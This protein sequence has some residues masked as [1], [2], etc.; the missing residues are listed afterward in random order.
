MNT[1]TNEVDD[2][3]F[4]ALFNG[5]IKSCLEFVKSDLLSVACTECKLWVTLETL[6]FE[7]KSQSL[8]AAALIRAWGCARTDILIVLLEKNGGQEEARVIIETRKWLAKELAISEEDAGG[9]IK[10]LI[11]YL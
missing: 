6:C 3:S 7:E 10:R 11:P 8:V 1:E 2:D 9:I 4:I 5:E